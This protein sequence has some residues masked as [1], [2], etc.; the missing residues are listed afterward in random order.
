MAIIN[1]LLNNDWYKFTMG[2]AVRKF[3][4]NTIVG[5]RFTNRN[6]DFP[7]AHYVDIDELSDELA[8][9]RDL[10]FSLREIAYLESQGIIPNWYLAHLRNFRM[11]EIYAEVVGDQIEMWVE[12]VWD[13]VMPAEVPALQIITELVSRALAKEAGLGPSDI[14]R[15]GY[16]HLDE[17]VDFFKAHPVKKLA[18]FGTRRHYSVAW[19]HE[20]TAYL[21][22]KMG[23]QIAGISNVGL[24]QEFGYN[25]S[26]TIAHEYFIVPTMIQ[27]AL[28]TPDPI[29]VAQNEAMDHW[30]EL[31][32]DKWNGGILCAI[33]DT[34]GTDSFLRAFTPERAA[35]WRTF[36]QDSGDPL[37]FVDK[38]TTWLL[39]HDLD[40]ALYRLVHTDGLT[41]PIMDKLFAAADH[42]PTHYMDG[43]G[44]GT[45]QTNN[46]GVATHS[47]VWKPDWVEVEGQRIP[48]VKLSDNLAKAVGHDPAMIER[49]KELA[50]YTNQFS[51]LQNV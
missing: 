47:L 39:E 21:V 7:L 28:G 6:K 35:T 5:C 24:A 50:G 48:C 31:Y 10:R 38:V 49:V 43:Y 51:E 27:V 37:V 45:S 26:G 33:P 23:D 16:R 8:A 30:E 2:P 1:T 20:V 4:P 29:G 15:E 46:V 11:P 9:L 44:Q 40:P 17:L 41:I 19:E 14:R 32:A 42:H 36:K 12:G 18:L 22:Y 25:L 3:Y 34:F 13:D